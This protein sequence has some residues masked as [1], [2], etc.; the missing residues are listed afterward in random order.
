MHNGTLIGGVG[1]HAQMGLHAMSVRL[2]SETYKKGIGVSIQ[3]GMPVLGG[4]DARMD[5]WTLRC[6]AHPD[7][8]ATTKVRISDAQ[9]APDSEITTGS[10]MS[11]VGRYAHYPYNTNTHCRNKLLPWIPLLL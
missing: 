4:G 9:H 6:W 5:G 7:V 8:T 3:T 11:G 1:I 2:R 10:C